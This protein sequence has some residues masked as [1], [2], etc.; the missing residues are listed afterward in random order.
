M[1]TKRKKK[2]IKEKDKI[3]AKIK[4]IMFAALTFFACIILRIL[5]LNIFMANYY[6]MKLNNEKE[7]YVYG[8]SV[9]R[10]RI[11]DRNGKVLVGNKAVKSISARGKLFRSMPFFLRGDPHEPIFADGFL[12]ADNGR[13]V[14][15]K[16]AGEQNGLL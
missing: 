13:R 16:W 1:K 4:I 10:G 7:T 14:S 11:L 15:E 5:Y 8:E 3:N 9:P 6:N 2:T 12:R